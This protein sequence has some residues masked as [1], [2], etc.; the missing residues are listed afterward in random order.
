MEKSKKKKREKQSNQNYID[1]KL[2]LKKYGKQKEKTSHRHRVLVMLGGAEALNQRLCLSWNHKDCDLFV[3]G[4]KIKIS[5]RAKRIPKSLNT[6]FFMRQS[7]ILILNGG[8]SS[9]AEGLSLIKPMVVIPIPGHIEQKTNALWIQ[10]N[11]MG[12]SS[13]WKDMEKSIFYCVQ[14]YCFFKEKLFQ[15]NHFDGAAQAVDIIHRSFFEK[16]TCQFDRRL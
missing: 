5:G 10:N 16:T 9:L 1:H 7:T 11:N 15:Y 3:L 8:A 12:V 14:H 2:S 13:S 6:A 4:E